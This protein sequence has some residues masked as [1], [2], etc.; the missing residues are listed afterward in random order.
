[1]NPV[2]GLIRENPSGLVVCVIGLGYVGLPLA[3]A[4]AEHHTVVGYDINKARLEALKAGG[5]PLG[6]HT[7]EQ[8]K[9][10]TFTSE[11]PRRPDVFVVAVPT[12]I[13][14]NKQPDLG[15]LRGAAELIRDCAR[16]GSL[17]IV[18][19]TV[20]PGATEEIFGPV[21]P[22]GVSLGYSPERIVP[23][24]P[25]ESQGD[26]NGA[27]H[28]LRNTTKVV[29]GRDPETT[30]AVRALYAGV[31]DSLHVAPTIEVAEAAKILEN[32]QRDLNIALMNEFSMICSRLGVDTQAV[33][34]AAAT[35]WN[36]HAYRP[37]L[38]G[39]HCISV[40]PYYLAFQAKRHG[41]HPN[42][43]LAGRQ[44]ND[45]M[46][47]YVARETVKRMMGLGSSHHVL[48][49]GATFKENCDD[50]RNSRVPEIIEE[51]LSYGLQVYIH[52]P[53]SGLRIGS[54]YHGAL[55][56]PCDPWETASY[57]A[58]IVAVSHD[59]FLTEEFQAGLAFKAVDTTVISD[60]KGVYR[61][62]PGITTGAYW[63][64]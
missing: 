28:T 63:H 20:Y 10:I 7:P 36:F 42:V 50:L 55:V 39:G 17:V 35:K 41:F 22:Q 11:R 12:D 16:P 60:V 48:V 44:I 33:I 57:G 62:N 4:F 29:S 2:L 13:D 21:L 9:G 32:T 8:L 34:D 52:D 37:G 49:L 26:L 56:V 3:V 53:V 5:D 31:C 23:G 43:I 27:K 14:E 18:E 1:M 40:D 45:R 24:K 38:V 46:G 25:R 6:L 64:L 51:L 30:E 15:P 19:S 61:R 47:T 58:V 54:D 59:E